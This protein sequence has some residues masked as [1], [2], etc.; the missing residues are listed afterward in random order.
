MLHPFLNKIWENVSMQDD[1]KKGHLVKL[2]KK[3]DMSSCNN[4]GGIMLLSIPGKF[5][6]RII[7]ERLKTAVDKTLWEK[8]AGL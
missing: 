2:S 1:W 7:L 8:K 4:W 3:G 6:T 5:L